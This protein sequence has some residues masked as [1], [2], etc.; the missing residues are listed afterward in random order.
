[1]TTLT[2]KRILLTGGTSGIGQSAAILAAQAGADVAFCGL[3][4]DDGARATREAIEAAGGRAF[5]QAVDLGDTDAA[6]DFARSA[7]D[8]LGGVD[9]LV[10]N[11]GTNFWHGVAGASKTQIERCFDLN[12]YAGWAISQ[13]V[14]PAMKAAGGGKIVNMASIHGRFTNPGVFP[15]NVSKAMVIALTTSQS[16]EWGRD[17]IQ[18]VAIAPGMIHTPLLDEYLATVDNA[19]AEL[20]RL[21]AR[22]PLGRTGRPEDVG[23]LIV[24]LLSD[25]NRFISGNTIF[26]DGGLSTMDPEASYEEWNAD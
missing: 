7:I 3:R 20:N 14:Y 26:V 23:S 19:E 1:M 8:F 22:Y 4:D 21:T 17:N 2:D 10:N 24:Y 9:G 6:R 25:E 5:F 12:F 18:A 16:L 15:Y 13:E 11:A